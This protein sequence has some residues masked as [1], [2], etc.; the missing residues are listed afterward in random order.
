MADGYRLVMDQGSQAGRVFPLD[1]EVIML[2]RD[3]SCSVPLGEIQVSRRH[4]RIVHQ[5]GLWVIEDLGSTNG[6][7]VNGM[8]LSS[9]HPL[10]NG[11]VI[12]I[13]DAVTLTF[14]G[15]GIPAAMEALG[16]QPAAQP[17]APV[18]APAPQAAPA[19]AAAPYEQ[20]APA[21]PPQFEQ[22]E[23]VPEKKG[24]KKWVFMGCGCLA[25]LAITACLG[26]VVL[27]YLKLLPDVFYEPLRWV[28]LF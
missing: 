2:G 5:G 21:S 4:A 19:Y 17:A 14:S 10:S 22:F 9:P 26:V 11:D 27:D 28:G 16:G 1:Q 25:L 18:Y 8:R 23:Q 15:S 20:P 6:T 24:G 3:P 12:G 13:S 7:F